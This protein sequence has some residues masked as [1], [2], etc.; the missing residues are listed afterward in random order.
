MRVNKV[1]FCFDDTV[2]KRETS[3]FFG[4]LPHLIH[5]IHNVDA[6]HMP[7]S[8]PY[9]PPLIFFCYGETS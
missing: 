1:V 9:F 2:I 5:I 3:V 6:A 4:S 8:S 7:S